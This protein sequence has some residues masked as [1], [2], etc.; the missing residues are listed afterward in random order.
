MVVNVHGGGGV[1]RIGVSPSQK[2]HFPRE[3]A[4]N[5][6]PLC[7]VC[8]TKCVGGGGGTCPRVGLSPE[9][10]GVASF[11]LESCA[12]SAVRLEGKEDEK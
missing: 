11:V 3:L 8:A 4:N 9:L 5:Q 2:H 1:Q 6:L 7:T 12:C 10:T